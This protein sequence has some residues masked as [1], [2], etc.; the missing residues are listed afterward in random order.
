MLDYAERLQATQGLAERV[1]THAHVRGPA[2][3][4]ASRGLGDRVHQTDQLIDHASID[5]RERVPLE[6]LL[7]ARAAHLHEAVDAGGLL[8]LWR[9][10]R[11]AERPEGTVAP[12]VLDSWPVA[13]APL[14]GERQ[15]VVEN[16]AVL[17]LTGCNE[18]VSLL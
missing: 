12:R 17:D 6:Q 4:G 3:K 5:H 9:W 16:T 13:E 2:R 11:L 8:Q 15:E 14:S 10:C 7:D 18:P 1:A